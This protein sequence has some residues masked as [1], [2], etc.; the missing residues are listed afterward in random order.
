M[1]Y[2]LIGYM[3]LF[4]DR[5][6]EVWPI[7]GDL[8]VERIYI[9][10]TLGIWLLY[11][12]KKF[13]PNYLHLFY[14][15]F[16]G[17]ILLC[18]VMSPWSEQG[19][20][21]VENWLKIA[22]FYVLLVSSASDEKGL[23]RLVVGFV[24][25]MGLYLLHS[26]REFLGGRHTYRMG[27]VRMIGVDTSLGDPN[28]FGASIVFALPFVVA[29][30]QIYQKKWQ[31][32][33]TI[34]YLG[35]SVLCVLL[36]GS[37]GSLVGVLVWGL[38]IVFRSR[39]RGRAFL[40]FALLSPVIFLALPSSLQNRFETIINPDVG[41]KNAKESG[42]GR[43]EGYIKG[44]EL[45]ERN[46]LTGVGPGV[47][48]QAT[49]SKIES[50]SLYAQLMGELGGLGIVSFSMVVVGLF[51]NVLWI[52]RA[53]KR[54]PFG[55]TSAIYPISNAIGMG[56]FLLLFEGLFG[57]NLFRHN[58]LWYG[59]FLIIGR[60]I[61]ENRLQA[62]PVTPYRVYSGRFRIQTTPFRWA[63]SNPP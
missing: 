41:P 40:A 49:R 14:V 48:R 36:T 62:I 43:I 61:I 59:A 18:W 33:L 9:L 3:F 6:F 20:F 1:H 19:Q 28:S 30:W 34:G 60:A 51:A 57:H 38:W 53:Q 13:H 2:L 11:P 15:L 31:R 8:H 24:G 44:L 5:P 45:L 52:R 54:D 26:F 56:I 35:L 7:L 21:A 55:S 29:F 32:L 63:H 27:I 12:D 58:W 37:R 39:Y 22:V 17:A 16:G 46:P 10:G 4:I 50:H 25:V 42:E 23:K 47:W